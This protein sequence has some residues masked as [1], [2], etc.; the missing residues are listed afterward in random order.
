M[1]KKYLLLQSDLTISY[2]DNNCY[3]NDNQVEREKSQCPFNKAEELKNDFY[4]KFLKKHYKH[5]VVLTAA[6]TSLD[7]GGKS[8]KTR[9]GLWESCQTELNEICKAI[10]GNE[11]NSFTDG[12]EIENCKLGKIIKAKDIE[13]LLSYIILIEKTDSINEETIKEKR[14]ALEN[15][16]K[17]ECSLDLDS[18]APH[19]NFLNKISARKNS[20]PRV[21]LF[22]TNYDILFEQAAV[23]AGFVLI[24]GFSFTQPRTFSGRWF[25]LDIVYREKTRLKQEESFLSKVIHLYKLHGS[26]NWERKEDKII[27]QDNSKNPLMIYPAS[28]K[29]E[30]SYEQPYFEMMSRFQQALRKEETLLIV[31]GFGFR[32]K[33]INNVIIEA[34]EQNPSFQL[35]IVDY[36]ENKGISKENLSDFFVNASEWKVKRNVNIIFD[37][38]GDFTDKFPENKT[39]LINTNEI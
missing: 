37:T 18:S 25:D 4:N 28:N 31:L 30:S 7:N 3:S 1:D 34:V 33:H 8:G 19:K 24:D 36:N 12:N 38:F 35:L 14:K 5:L 32:D 29:Y 23:E 13:E 20:D 39:Y 21:Q 2:D 15:K 10:S 6:G 9:D 11:I 26:V 16:I 22:T 27:Q 17:D